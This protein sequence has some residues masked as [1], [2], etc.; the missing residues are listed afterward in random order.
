M[1]ELPEVEVVRRGVDKH[2]RGRTFE[3]V[4]V[5]HPRANR[6]Q[7]APLDQLLRGRT[8]AKVARR[9]KFMWLEFADE[10]LT[11]P[12]RDVLFVHLGMSGQMRVGE[13][14]SKHVRIVA[15]FDDGTEVSF[16]D[17]R[18]F[19]YWLLAP[20]L[21]IAHIAVDPLESGFDLVAT[22]RALR[23]KKTAVKT[24][25]LDQ[26]VVSGVGNIYADESLWAAQIK[27]TKRASTL[28]QR[29]AVALLEAAAAVME[30]ALEV[31]GTSFDELYVNVN[32]ESGYF[33]RS[34]NAYGQAGQPCP[35]C[36]T[37]IERIVLGGRSTHYCPHC[38]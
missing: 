36:G 16:I 8:I 37:E 18:T 22:A 24:A 2:L 32:G 13:Q 3:S 27:P 7:E 10:D 5:R 34:L 30:R 21:K 11:D 28:L 12:G 17:Q 15:T 4:D 1:P 35:R 14:N 20:W 31:G 23:R 9:G 6:G 33:A 26:T 25:L 38:Q 29:D 19:G